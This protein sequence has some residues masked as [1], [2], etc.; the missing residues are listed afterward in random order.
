MK[1]LSLWQPWASLVAFGVKRYETRFWP[2]R[3]RGELVICATREL[4]QEGRDAFLGSAFGFALAKHG[5][6]YPWDLPLGCALCVV[7]LEDVIYLRDGIA[8][9]PDAAN[10]QNTPEAQF[11]DFTAGR[12]AWKL[13][14]VRA[15]AKT[16]GVRGAQ[17]LFELGTGEELSIRSRLAGAAP[18]SPYVPPPARASQA[19]MF[20]AQRVE[21]E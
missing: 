13:G 10:V 6:L 18:P 5:I 15:L 2:T 21:D 8:S 7:E 17:G 20:D 9:L 3:Y 12:Y 19:E 4:R 16:V 14:N 1:A 11:G